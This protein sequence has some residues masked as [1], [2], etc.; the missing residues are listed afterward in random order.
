MLTTKIQPVNHHHHPP[1]EVFQGGFAVPMRLCWVAI[2]LAALLG[3]CGAFLPASAFSGMS[4][5]PGNHPLG[6]PDGRGGAAASRG[7]AGTLCGLRMEGGPLLV[8][9]AS[10]RTGR[11]VVKELVGRGHDVKALVRSEAG[12]SSLANSG[13]TV[14]RGDVCKFDELVAAMEGCRACIACHGSERPTKP[15]KDMMYKIWDPESVFIGEWPICDV[16]KQTGASAH[17]RILL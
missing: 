5:R 1:G 14:V 8:T 3:E 15:V 9:G 12:A 11:L 4:M 13:A 2:T 10:G 7:E 16:Q 17:A 6:C